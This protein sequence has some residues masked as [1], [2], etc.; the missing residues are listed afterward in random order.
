MADLK[1]KHVTHAKSNKVTE[2]GKA[3]LPTAEMLNYGE[4]AINYAKGVETI[5][6][7][8]AENEIVTFSSDEQIK[9]ML[10]DNQGV[11]TKIEGIEGESFLNIVEGE[12]NEETNTITY[13]VSTSN[14]A[15]VEALETLTQEVI[16]NELVTAAA[17]TDLDERKVD[18]TDLDKYAL[19][20]ELPTKVSE[21][22]NDSNYLTEHQDISHLATKEELPTYS[23]NKLTDEEIIALGTNVREAF[24]MVDKNNE[25]C[26]EVI[27]VYKDSS[28][29]SVSLVGTEVVTL[30]G[31]TTL[32]QFLRFVYILEN[33]SESTVDLDVKTFL[34]EAEFKHGLQV[35]EAGEVSVKIDST[36]E[37]HLSVSE[38]GIK[39]AETDAAK[40]DM[41]KKD[42]NGQAY[43]FL[44]EKG[45]YVSRPLTNILNENRFI[46]VDRN[47]DGNGIL[48]ITL[49]EAPDVMALY[50][51]IETLKSQ[52]NT[53]MN[54]IMGGMRLK[55]VTQ[56]EYDIMKTNG[57]LDDNT[58]YVIGGSGLNNEDELESVE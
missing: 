17:L 33:G 29:K 55:K 46:T 47:D 34:Q 39:L 37:A 50:E 25:Q 8:N 56:A 13:T 53:I 30:D 23:L 58:L 52:I 35:N 12:L 40:L 28:L 6:L 27:K 26:G 44:N 31:T 24:K 48:N 43:W 45:E 51:E 18:N 38:N 4:I 10:G 1:I 41:L 49:K 7:K 15:S 16:D 5:S 11:I 20:T 57:T 54:D 32:A 22:E 19:K 3:K 42:E 2:E 36:S 21:L 9:A 14:I